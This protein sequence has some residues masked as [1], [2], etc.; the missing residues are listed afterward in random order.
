MNQFLFLLDE[1]VNPILRDALHRSEPEMTVWRVGD[2]G[3]PKNGASDP[4]ILD[5][6]AR[7]E[8]TLITNNRNSM[9]EHLRE[10]V[11][12]GRIA[13]AV[14]VLNAKMTTGQTVN[15][16]QLVW[17][18]SEPREYENTIRFLPFFP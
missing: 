5:W 13:P 2:P 7:N 9:F 17:R 14:F 10:F 18:A 4:A 16:L 11:A 3:V 15:E 1:N 12:G 8:Y 6:C